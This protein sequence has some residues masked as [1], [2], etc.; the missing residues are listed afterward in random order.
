[1]G[2]PNPEN[3]TEH[4]YNCWLIAF[5]YLPETSD[6]EGYDK[7]SILQLLLLHD[8]AEVVTGDVD[9]RDKMIDPR[10]HEQEE[11]DV[12]HSLFLSGT[13]PKSINLT[14]YIDLWNLWC[15]QS[16]NINVSIA[17]DIDEIQAI[18]QACDYYLK[19][20]ERFVGVETTIEYWL[21]NIQNI[22]SDIGRN[23]VDA[24]IVEN[25]EFQTFVPN[26]LD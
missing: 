10:R 14:N 17:K 6:I 4:I 3:V 15:N 13:Y 22:K 20:P 19:Y 11:T 21:S 5:I 8:L 23:I 1:M 16:D 18:Y 12:M 7:N 24:L 26:I 25:P 2:V 9:R